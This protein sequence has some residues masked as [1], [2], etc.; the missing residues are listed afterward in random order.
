MILAG[1]LQ[2]CVLRSFGEVVPVLS[3]ECALE[4]IEVVA[5]RNALAGVVC[6]YPL[7]HTCGT[8]SP[9]VADRSNANRLE[10]S[11]DRWTDVC[12]TLQ[13]GIR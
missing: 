7:E 8:D 1:F 6:L 10:A 13:N 3:F 9:E 2:K 11:R 4:G 12:Q 5:N